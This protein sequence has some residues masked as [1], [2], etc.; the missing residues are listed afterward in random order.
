MANIQVGVNLA[1]VSSFYISQDSELL[2]VSNDFGN[3]FIKAYEMKNN[4][5]FNH[6]IT[7]SNKIYGGTPGDTDLYTNK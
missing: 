3:G 7:D 2:F 1:S 6:E 4:Y 5:A